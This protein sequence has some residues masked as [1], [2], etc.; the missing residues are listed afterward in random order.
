MQTTKHWQ[1]AFTFLACALAV[2]APEMS[3]ATTGNPIGD[4]LCDVVGWMTGPVGAGIATLA[5]I[6][7]GVGALLGKVSWGMAIIVGLGVAIVFGAPSVIESLS[8]VSST[9]C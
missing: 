7:I 5:V 2:A 1:H 3:L 4:V 6:I 9:T 8:S